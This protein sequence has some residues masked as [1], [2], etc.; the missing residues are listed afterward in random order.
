L[1]IESERRESKESWARMLRDL[2]A[3]GLRPWR[4]TVADGHLGIWSA[5]GEVFSDGAELRCWNHRL[6]NVLDHLPKKDWSAAKELL[7]KMPYA[8]KQG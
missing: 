6:I 7:R 3:R 8:I 1:A 5:L 4:A 2:F